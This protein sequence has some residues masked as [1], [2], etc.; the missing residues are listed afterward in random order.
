MATSSEGVKITDSFNE[1]FVNGDSGHSNR[2]SL[3]SSNQGRHY[4]T[5]NKGQWKAN[6]FLTHKLVE[7]DT[8]QGIALKYSIPVS[9]HT[10]NILYHNYTNNNHNKGHSLD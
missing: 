2:T 10:L 1:T 5:V 4:G 7:S 3:V 8:L 6:G 9:P